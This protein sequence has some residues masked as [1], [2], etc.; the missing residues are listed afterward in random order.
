MCPDSVGVSS[1]KSTPAARISSALGVFRLPALTTSLPRPRS[2]SSRASWVTQ[3]TSPPASSQICAREPDSAAT[4]VGASGLTGAPVS[5]RKVSSP[6]AAVASNNAS[7]RAKANKR[8]ISS[9]LE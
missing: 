3:A 2:R 4:R 7:I 6:M 5:S 1:T 9:L 8:R